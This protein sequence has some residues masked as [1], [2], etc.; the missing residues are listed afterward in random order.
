M[1]SGNVQSRPI[2]DAEKLLKTVFTMPEDKQGAAWLL[3][4]GFLSGVEAH[5]G[6]YKTR[7]VQ[8]EDN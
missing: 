8:E 6:L 1:L 4:A 2:E 7:T 5:D 3:L